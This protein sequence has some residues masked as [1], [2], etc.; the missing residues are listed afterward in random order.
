MHQSLGRV[1]SAVVKPV[2]WD[3]M[4]TISSRLLLLFAFCLPS[5]RLHMLVT[6]RYDVS[7]P[8]RIRLLEI[9][10]HTDRITAMDAFDLSPSTTRVP[11]AGEARTVGSNA[12][13]NAD[14]RVASP[15]RGGSVGSWRNTCFRW[16]S[17][18]EIET[19]Q[20]GA[21]VA[22]PVVG[23][24]AVIRP[25][26]PVDGQQLRWDQG[27][28]WG[29][30]WVVEGAGEFFPVAVAA[31]P[32][33]RVPSSVLPWDGVTGQHDR[34]ESC[35]RRREWS[36][37][38]ALPHWRPIIK[39]HDGEEETGEEEAISGGALTARSKQQPRFSYQTGALS[40]AGRGRGC[41]R[42][43]VRRSD[44]IALGGGGFRT[45]HSDCARLGGRLLPRNAL[46]LGKRSAY[47]GRGQGEELEGA[48]GGEDV[49]AYEKYGRDE[50]RR[51]NQDISVLEEIV[52]QEE[53]E[54]DEAIIK[55]EAAERMV[56]FT[57]S[58]DGTAK[59]W[60]AVTG[61]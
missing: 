47:A 36:A 44:T 31:A 18:Q 6:R 40:S 1:F 57:G 46:S 3:A 22:V 50:L 61:R 48:S 26:T 52:L 2:W 15:N 54:T 8:S 28:G 35:G 59:A 34:Q 12:N 5:S 51:R 16:Y 42:G 30:G 27:H 32:A 4:G 19:A 45:G 55:S 38:G 11:D 21:E 56:L 7:T 39:E 41:G 9:R 33:T 43:S 60:D 17:G 49:E 20:N 23:D 13:I 10:T 58:D 14:V 24:A 29:N 37:T 53:K 25:V